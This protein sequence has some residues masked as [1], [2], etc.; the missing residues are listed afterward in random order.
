[1]VAPGRELSAG[2]DAA[3]RRVIR[4]IDHP[5][6]PLSLSL[7]GDP[8]SLQQILVNLLLNA[9]RVLADRDN[10]SI[11]VSAACTSEGVCQIDVIDDGPGIPGEIAGRLFERYPEVFEDRRAAL[12]RV[13]SL[14]LRYAE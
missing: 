4:V 10:G 3:A 2:R 7:G 9:T 12:D 8:I 1:M 6:A 11:I 14:A 5:G 13:A